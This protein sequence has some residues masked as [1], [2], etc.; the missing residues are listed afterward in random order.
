MPSIPNTISYVITSQK[1][2]GYQYQI[3]NNMLYILSDGEGTNTKHGIMWYSLLRDEEGA[4]IPNTDIMC[5][6]FSVTKRV[7]I[8]QTRYHTAS[9]ALD[10]VYLSP[11]SA[12]YRYSYYYGRWH[13]PDR[14]F[15][16]EGANI[17]NTISYGIGKLSTTSLC[18]HQ[19]HIIVT[20]IITVG[21]T[22][23]DI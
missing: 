19:V 14:F 11:L 15:K 13:P 22:R 20:L 17:P 9:E 5:C 1:R 6:Y 3:R 21:G 12:H 10:N 18:R 23:T 16:E 8:Y 7:S 2:R 4:K